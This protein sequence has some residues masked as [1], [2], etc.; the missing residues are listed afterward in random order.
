MVIGA[1]LPTITMPVGIVWRGTA[2][3]LAV[4]TAWT[5]VFEQIWDGSVWAI[6]GTAVKNVS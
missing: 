3:T 2:P 5:I 6:R 4:S 1:S